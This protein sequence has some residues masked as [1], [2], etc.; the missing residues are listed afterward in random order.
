MFLRLCYVNQDEKRLD[1]LHYWEKAE[2][3]VFSRHRSYQTTKAGLSLGRLTPQG[4]LWYFYLLNL[5][6][7]KNVVELLLLIQGRISL[8]GDSS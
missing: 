5:K 6:K 8:F 7:K 4:F 1:F 2:G 3:E